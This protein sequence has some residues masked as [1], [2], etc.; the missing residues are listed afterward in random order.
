MN[1]GSSR[2]RGLPKEKLKSQRF[3]KK[4]G[5]KSPVSIRTQWQI[6]KMP[7]GATQA[8]TMNNLRIVIFRGKIRTAPTEIL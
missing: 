6:S 7:H 8:F 4:P 5:A 2:I 1:K 3:K